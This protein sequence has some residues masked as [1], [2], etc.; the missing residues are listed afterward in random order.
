M[1]FQDYQNNADIRPWSKADQPGWNPLSIY[2][3]VQRTDRQHKL[4]IKI[5]SI[6]VDFP[7]YKG[8]PYSFFPI[9]A[10]L[11]RYHDHYNPWRTKDL[12]AEHQEKRFIQWKRVSK[13]AE[14]TAILI[15]LAR[16]QAPR[17]KDRHL[18]KHAAQMQFAEV[19]PYPRA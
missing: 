17:L 13:P 19:Y 14:M 12:S 4:D 2:S 7:N 10:F 5:E 15:A 6:S 1:K 16:K 18:E 3:S 11:C 8:F 9:V